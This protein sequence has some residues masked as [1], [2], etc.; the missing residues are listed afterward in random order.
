MFLKTSTLSNSCFY[1][2]PKTFSSFFASLVGTMC[3][4]VI[5]ITE[6]HIM[7][8]FFFLSAAGEQQIKKPWQETKNKDASIF[9]HLSL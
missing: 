1:Q 3:F 7:M 4:T 2:N 6:T 5:L 9:M 8:G